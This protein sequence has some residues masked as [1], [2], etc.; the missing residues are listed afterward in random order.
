MTEGKENKEERII[1]ILETDIPGGINVYSGLARIKGVSWSF[2][3]AVCNILKIDKKK[4]IGELS[5]KELSL[6]S[7]IVKDPKI[8]NFLLNRR[9]DLETGKNVHLTGS[10]LDLRKEFDIKRLKKIKSYKGLRHALGLPVRGQRTR[11]HF[12]KNKSMGVVKKKKR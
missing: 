10:D 5:E 8:P 6:I 1:R 9:N 2:S 11:S 7:E 3:S 12:R 4:K